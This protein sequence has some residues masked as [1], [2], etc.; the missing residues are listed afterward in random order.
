M[1]TGSNSHNNGASST[2]TGAESF[3]L[4][5]F[6]E[7]GRTFHIPGSYGP[8]S[9]EVT[10]IK[11]AHEN[12]HPV[13]LYELMQGL[14]DYG[15]GH[16]PPPRIWIEY[17]SGKRDIYT[18]AE[19]V[20]SEDDPIIALAFINAGSGMSPEDTIINRHGGDE[21]TLGMR[22]KGLKLACSYLTEQGMPVQIKSH[23]H[24]QT[25]EGAIHLRPT[26]SNVT[27]VLRM[28][29]VWK[30]KEINP[31]TIIRVEKPSQDLI[32]ELNK[33]KDYFLFAN[34][35]YPDAVIVPRAQQSWNQHKFEVDTGTITLIESISEEET[36][37]VD[38]LRVPIRSKSIFQ[39]AFEGLSS[40]KDRSNKVKRS[41]DSTSAEYDS[42][43]KPVQEVLYKLQ[44]KNLLKL[45]IQKAIEK[46]GRQN[47]YIECQSCWMSV[48][49]DPKTAVMVK[50]IWFELYGD[51]VIDDNTDFIDDYKKSSEGKINVQYASG[52][53]ASFLTAAGITSLKSTIKMQ[54]TKIMENLAML[55]V[56]SAKE[57]DALEQFAEKVARAGGEISM[58]KFQG[59]ECL[60]I[61]LPDVACEEDDYNGQSEKPWGTIIRIAA[62]IAFAGKINCN[63][64][65]IQKGE[66]AREIKITSNQDW[67]G[68]SKYKTQI[69]IAT[70]EKT[71]YQD[72]SKFR[73]GA[74]HIILSGDQINATT[75]QDR[76]STIIEYFLQCVDTIQK[77]IASMPLRAKLLAS[78]RKKNGAHPQVQVAKSKSGI[79][80]NTNKD[81]TKIETVFLSNE[82]EYQEGYYI[83]GYGT[84]LQA[85]ADEFGNFHPY[86][87]NME[88]WEKQDIPEKAS[89]KYST[90]LVQPEFFGEIELPVKTGERIVSFT[91]ENNDSVK[92]YRDA[93]T[94]T[95]KAK[96]AA[97]KL[98]YFTQLEANILY[99]TQKPL[100]DERENILE[101]ESLNEPWASFV[102]KV[103]NDR[104][105]SVENK[106]QMAQ[107]LWME[108]FE[109]NNDPNIRFW[110]NKPKYIVTNL[111]NT[112]KGICNI[113]ATGFA[114]ILR[115]ID[116]PSRVAYGHLIQDKPGTHMWVEYWNGNR[117]M[118][119]ESQIGIKIA[120]PSLIPRDTR[121]KKENISKNHGHIAKY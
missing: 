41:H 112:G 100:P 23:Y 48:K 82:S 55:H 80:N 78:K 88:H 117:W 33:A 97:K 87:E 115:S 25:W 61:S 47:N 110:G 85:F 98:T 70:I 18:G 5:H 60:H 111:V 54:N 30:G 109:Y 35:Q 94:G 16:N 75:S 76:L 106:V 53:F 10:A 95:Y 44:D 77:K 63:I 49:M 7:V 108:T 93:R 29:G 3:T 26:E 14:V 89:K 104:N 21:R 65:A 90:K 8:S 52:G 74:T 67:Y 6:R 39:W 50:E 45:F 83:T 43:S 31:Q 92:I 96:G 22:G 36:I 99:G 102:Q 68:S 62:I 116:I 66:S 11:K 59:E 28:E 81:R 84:S 51:A 73:E 57:S 79:G 46:E 71:Q 69:D 19:V 15:R 105:L 114:A 38:G 1:D 101:R 64:F 86:W 24:S 9:P 37:Y 34:P 121:I 119:I 17:R 58:I 120:T 40:P 72:L 4:D 32:K 42:L 91:V 27:H 56:P 113:S 2:G 13:A 12:G 107:Q 118:A 103:R 20:Q